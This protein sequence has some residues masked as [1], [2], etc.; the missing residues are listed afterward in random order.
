V[1]WLKKLAG[2]LNGANSRSS[3][4]AAQINLIEQTEWLK[5]SSRSVEVTVE[6]AETIQ[7]ERATRTF[8]ERHKEIRL[9]GSGQ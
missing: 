5:K 4:S 7:V 9:D 3:E 2:R 1:N 6:T 8:S